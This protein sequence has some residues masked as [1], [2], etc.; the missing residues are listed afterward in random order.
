M[1]TPTPPAPFGLIL[2]TRPFL[3]LEKL[4][5]TQ[6][7]ARFPSHPP[8]SHIVAF[9][10]PGTT[11][12]ATHGAAVYIQLP[13]S[14]GFKLLGA[15]GNEKQSAIFKINGYS[16]TDNGVTNGVVEVDMDADI[17]ETPG[18]NTNP[19]GDFMVGISLEP[20]ASIATQLAS[21]QPARAEEMST[22]LTLARR[23]PPSTKVLAQRIIK[24]AFN[25]LASFAG[26]TG[27][28]EVVPLKAFQEWW[29][30]FERRVEVDPGFLEREVDG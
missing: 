10:L 3:P 1:P 8:F 30:K 4:S 27:G 16:G 14:A 19:P 20:A 13:G 24:N 28:S 15:L 2:P 7:A 9:L 11:L 23:P 6:F 29:V 25:F 5:E 12:P 26:G 21:I 22:A 18:G 17:D